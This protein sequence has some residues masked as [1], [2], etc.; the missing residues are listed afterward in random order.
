MMGS[1]KLG[2]IASRS[3]INRMYQIITGN[4]IVE[5]ICILC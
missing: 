3:D 2:G 1:I 4:T 5:E